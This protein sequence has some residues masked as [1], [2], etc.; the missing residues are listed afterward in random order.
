V[1]PDS[2]FA[3]PKGSFPDPLPL[4]TEDPDASPG[5]TVTVACSW[6]PYVR[7]ALQQLLLQSTWK[8]S[9]PD[10]LLLAQQRAFNLIDLFQ[11][12]S[13]AVLPF[14]CPYDFTLADGG[15]YNRTGYTPPYTDDQIGVWA[16]LTGWVGQYTTA[17]GINRSIAG[18]DIL[19]GVGSASY[20]G[21]DVELYYTAGDVDSG[22]NVFSAYL[23]NGGST[24]ASLDINQGALPN[25]FSTQST[26]F[27]AV[28]ADTFGL[29]VYSNR[30]S[31][32]GSD[33]GGVT[34]TKVTLRGVGTPP[35]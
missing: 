17:P 16:T 6:L 20:T 1:L 32:I 35:C 24:V 23:L 26:T 15:F 31:P 9:D 4:P 34:V 7:G 12:C 14:A 3:V 21:I 25:G 30:V 22:A 8:T 29:I 19:A 27:S 28:I 2:P 5:L 10:Q 33:A 18:V 11:E 13:T